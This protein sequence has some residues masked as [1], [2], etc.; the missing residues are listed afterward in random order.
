MKRKIS[1][2]ENYSKIDSSVIE[3]ELDSNVEEE[4]ADRP[5]ES[6]NVY[7]RAVNIMKQSTFII[8]QDTENFTYRDIGKSKEEEEEDPKKERKKIWKI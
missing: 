2:F 8:L 1:Q 4:R 5:L 6:D 7:D 3:L